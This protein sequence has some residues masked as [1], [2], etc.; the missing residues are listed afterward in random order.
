MRYENVPQTSI[1]KRN[2]LNVYLMG[3]RFP[4]IELSHILILCESSAALR[5]FFEEIF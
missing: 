1:D 3:N 5:D 2:V 4:L